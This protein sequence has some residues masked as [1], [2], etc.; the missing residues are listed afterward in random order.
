MYYIVMQETGKIV[1]EQSR[2]S[3][4]IIQDAA[5]YFG[6]AVYAI[7]GE[8]SGYTAVPDKDSEEVPE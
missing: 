2:I 1:D 7:S 4:K 5:N 3:Q 6:G 8:H